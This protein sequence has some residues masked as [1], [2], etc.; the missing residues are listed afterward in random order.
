M[1]L[2]QSLSKIQK[3]I[4]KISVYHLFCIALIGEFINLAYYAG[5][6]YY[7]Q[8]LP[9]PFVWNK[10][11]SFMDFYNP[12]Y[13]VI[14]D[15]FYTTFNSVYPALNYYILKIFSLGLSSYV[16]LDPYDFRTA[17]SNLSIFL[18]LLYL[19]I[20]FVVTRLGEWRKLA[21]ANSVLSYWICAASVPVLF[22]LERGNLIFIALLF[23]A[24]YLHV[25]GSWAKA[26]YLALLIN[27]KPYFLILMIQYIN[28]HRFDRKMILKIGVILVLVF[29]IFGFFA[30]ID[31]IRFIKAYVGLARAGLSNGALSVDG[32]IALPH[33][34]S[35]LAVIEN[36]LYLPDTPAIY[37]N[38]F[39]AMKFIGLLGPV[40][41]LMISLIKPLSKE[42]LLIAA[43]LVIMNF[44]ISTGGYILL[45]YI[46]L[47][48]YFLQ[49]TQYRQLAILALLI[50]SLPLDF[51][52]VLKSP[53]TEVTSYFAGDIVTKDVELWVALGTVVRPICNFLVL[54][55]FSIGLL[56]KYQDKYF[57]NKSAK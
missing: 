41:L 19:L 49:K 4:E 25:N 18:V 10:Q 43:C 34:L 44:S 39:S 6:Y 51:I 27:M 29:V 48:P 15:G 46:I 16:V 22:A 31:F 11:D 54:T 5:F 12:L 33:N 3:Y 1:G 53:F 24:L 30:H 21:D 47:L 8:Y 2:K 36:I 57:F 42:E 32:I 55:L 52:H 50:F 13:W 23:L 38:W 26:F 7:H 40:I 17:N 9:A 45:I 56:K 37:A 14:K 20:I 35:S 28:R